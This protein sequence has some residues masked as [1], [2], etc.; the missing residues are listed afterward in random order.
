MIL[1]VENSLWKSDI[2]NLKFGHSEKTTK[3]WSNLPLDLT[4]FVAF[5]K[6]LNF[7]GMITLI[8]AA[9]EYCASIKVLLQWSGWK[10]KSDTLVVQLFRQTKKYP[11]LI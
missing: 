3:I 9:Q 4:N 1:D 5:L 10:W 6:N 7:I 2:G 11:L 8:I